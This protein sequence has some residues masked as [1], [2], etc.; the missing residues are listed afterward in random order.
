MAQA[1]VED[2][3]SQQRGEELLAQ[4]ALQEKQRHLKKIQNDNDRL[5][6]LLKDLMET[7][8]AFMREVSWVQMNK[9]TIKSINT[10]N[11][12]HQI[13][14]R[15]S[16]LMD[17]VD[18]SDDDQTKEVYQHLSNFISAVRANKEELTLLT[19]KKLEEAEAAIDS[20][21]DNE[22]AEVIASLRDF[23]YAP[24]ATSRN[25]GALI[26]EK[27]SVGHCSA[28]YTF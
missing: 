12:E 4:Y 10:D 23:G 3:E 19:L 25:L 18:S 8:A 26:S 6:E 24:S 1:Q 20:K 13:A 21:Q 16:Q 5:T 15:L 17:N 28:T 11:I 7:K 9:D 27:I 22:I 14:T 2:S